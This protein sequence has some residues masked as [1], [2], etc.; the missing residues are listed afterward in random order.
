MLDLYILLNLFEKNIPEVQEGHEVQEIPNQI[1]KKYTFWVKLYLVNH[2][3]TV[4][5]TVTCNRKI[6]KAIQ[7]YPWSLESLLKS[8]TESVFSA[9]IIRMK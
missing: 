4:I 8:R 7:A 6:N 1:Q 9:I 3:F 2:M 5:H